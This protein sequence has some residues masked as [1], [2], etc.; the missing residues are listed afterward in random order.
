MPDHLGGLHS[1]AELEFQ[2]LLGQDLLGFGRDL[3]VHA[4]QY[5]VEVFQ[6]RDLGAQAAP[7]RSQFQAD[8]S[9]ADHDQM[10]GHFGVGNGLVGS[11][12]DLAVRLDVREHGHLAA[13]GDD[14]VLGGEGLYLLAGPGVHGNLT[15]T[16]QPAV[17]EVARDL[18]FF[19]QAVDALGVGLDHVVLVGEH[20]GQIEFDRADLH[21]EA[22]EAVLGLVEVFAGLQEGFAG[23]ASHA[24][25]GA[26]QGVL[27]LHAGDLHAELGRADGGDV[28]AGARA[29]YD[30]VKRGLCHSIPRVIA[31]TLRNLKFSRAGSGWRRTAGQISSNILAGSSNASLIRFRNVTASRPSTMR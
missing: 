5:A 23:D 10:L 13:G 14:D 8:G 29:D 1:R 15:V 27:L 28:A 16:R 2:A 7:D 26:A 18:A 11:A 21:A 9:G 20:G 31:C 4:G 19:E 24:Q 22:A 30:E 12:D 17:A 6:H 3:R 25:A